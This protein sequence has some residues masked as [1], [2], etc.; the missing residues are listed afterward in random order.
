M[1][2]NKRKIN[3]AEFLNLLERN[4]SVFESISL[5]LSSMTYIN[6]V[7]LFS[8]LFAA[9]IFKLYGYQE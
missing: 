3:L 8:K 7:N 1:N 5:N 2:E 9:I 4:Y 6:I